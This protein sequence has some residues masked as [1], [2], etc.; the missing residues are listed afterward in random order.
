MA[1][2]TRKSLRV[3]KPL[4]GGQEPNTAA[5][6]T[7]Y[8]GLAANT[9]ASIGRAV[10]YLQLIGSILF[11]IVFLLIGVA[12]TKQPIVVNT[13][14]KEQNI[15]FYGIIIIIAAIAVM[16]YAVVSF[17]LVQNNASFASLMGGVGTVGFVSGAFR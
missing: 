16:I 2:H 11:G 17:W 5:A 7:N 3:R 1:K 12:V 6:K 9:S 13:E 10:S 4:R 8:L 15:K 14:G